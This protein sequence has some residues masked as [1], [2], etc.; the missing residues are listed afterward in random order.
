MSHLSSKKYKN[1]LSKTNFV[2]VKT[3]VYCPKNKI[4]KLKYFFYKPTFYYEI[5]KFFFSCNTIF[6]N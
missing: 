4:F 3:F 1:N 2:Q 6:S 5:V